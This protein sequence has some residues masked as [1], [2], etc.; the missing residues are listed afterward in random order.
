MFLFGLVRLLDETGLDAS[1]LTWVTR[2]ELA[3]SHPP[4]QLTADFLCCLSPN[5]FHTTQQV[6]A[7]M[8]TE[9]AFLSYSGPRHSGPRVL[10]II[11]D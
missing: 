1:T 10:L 3:M 4:L 8:V 9:K 6:T 2:G 7:A 11:E 5:K